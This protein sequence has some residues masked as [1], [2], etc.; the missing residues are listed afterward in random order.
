MSERGRTAGAW[1]LRSLRVNFPHGPLSLA[2]PPLGLPFTDVA[3]IPGELPSPIRAARGGLARSAASATRFGVALSGH[4]ASPATWVGLDDVGLHR[5]ML[6]AILIRRPRHAPC[7][8]EC[9]TAEYEHPEIPFLGFSSRESLA[10]RRRLK[11]DAS[12]SILTWPLRRRLLPND[13]GSRSSNGVSSEDFR[14]GS[15]RHG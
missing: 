4:L 6:S 12:R 10:R 3:A 2:L 5:S 7:R 1:R 14:T 13:P 8:P 9:S 11:R 15:D